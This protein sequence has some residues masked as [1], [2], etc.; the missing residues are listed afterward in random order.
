MSHAI[1]P[2]RNARAPG[3][4]FTGLSS[5]CSQY[6]SSR[7]GRHCRCFIACALSTASVLCM[8]VPLSSKT[9]QGCV[10]QHSGNCPLH[11]EHEV[12]YGAPVSCSDPCQDIQFNLRPNDLPV[13][14]GTTLRLLAPFLQSVS[15]RGEGESWGGITSHTRCLVYLSTCRGTH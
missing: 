1:G 2:G 7:C 12:Q 8:R 6:R 3:L 11:T 13:P 15:I 4:G 10:M 9:N 14:F 5:G